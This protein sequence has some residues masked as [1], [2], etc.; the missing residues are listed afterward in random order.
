ML[1]KFIRVAFLDKF[2]MESDSIHVQDPRGML[3]SLCSCNNNYF[4][5]M[6]N[7]PSKFLSISFQ[8]SKF[9]IYSIKAFPSI[10]VKIFWKK[11][12]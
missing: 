6:Q 2:F 11:K 9:Q 8:S 4:A 12:I 1:L 10:F 5:K 7:W 3:P